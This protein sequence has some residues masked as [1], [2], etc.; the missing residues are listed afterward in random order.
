MG[1]NPSLICMEAW[2]FQ[3]G[4][5]TEYPVKVLLANILNSLED[6]LKKFLASS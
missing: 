3:C 6:L 4:K 5:F 2:T 1:S